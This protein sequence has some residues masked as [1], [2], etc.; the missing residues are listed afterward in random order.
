[1]S[2]I[3]IYDEFGPEDV[4]MMQALYSRS[5]KSVTE[6]VEKVK[7]SGSG[8]FMETFYVGYGHSSIADCG[9]TTIFIEDISILG[10][11]AIQ[12]W[13]L[14]SGQETSTRYI[15]MGT[16]AIIDPLATPKSKEILDNWM[17]FYVNNQE[18]IQEY[19][20]S[21]YPRK[22]DE[23]E[24]IYMKAIKAR[25]FD[26]MRGFLP[27][28]ITTQLSWHTNLRQAWDHLAL[29]RHHPLPE[30]RQTSET[31]ISSL[32]EKYP[33]S[34]SHAAHAEQEAYRNKSINKYSYFLPSEIKDFS[35]ETTV[36]G[37]KLS[38]YQDILDNRP[39]K[40]NLPAF[41]A[42]LGSFTFEFLLDFGSFRDIQR[43]RNGVCR[44]PLLTTGLGFNNWYL[45]QLPK[46]MQSEA[47][48]LIEEQEKKIS[49]L[50]TTPEIKQYYIAMGFNV[51]CRVTYPLPAAVYVIELRSGRAV[52]PSLRAIAHQMHQ[53]ILKEFP[54]L[55]LHS[56]LDRDDWDI[57][58]GLAD[59]TAKK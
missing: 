55:K 27:A 23:D 57:R 4:A 45:E 52:H 54:G 19:L 42:D 48:K 2:N 25:G 44:M 17:R 39:E 8:K 33:H 11:K 6:H 41:M 35:M 30:V 9:S 1:M 31:I 38:I 3:F 49:A 36:N 18:R 14:Y 5:P 21:R 37:E 56:D 40:T 16:R 28:G 50:D 59:I 46:D 58:R 22:K 13:Q 20:V 32:K 43:H 53:A 10:D 29:L 26:I 34:F 47:T 24:V 7:A 51:A 12:D 15:D